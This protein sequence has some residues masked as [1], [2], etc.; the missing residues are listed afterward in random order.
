MDVATLA[1]AAAII[2]TQGIIRTRMAGDTELPYVGVHGNNEPMLRYLGEITGTK[3]TIVRRAY[4]KA[5]CAQHC[6]EK[7]Q[8]VQSVS[9]RW[10]VSGVK[11]TVL[12]HNLRP[13]LRLQHDDA[14]AALNVGVTAP[15][16]PAT[17]QKMREL[18]WDAP[19]FGKEAAA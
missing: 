19:T 17:I 3:V 10:S 15:F 14:I 8:H 6:A 12:L 4:S 5:G 16:K 9:G 2:D 13:Y 7:H 18:G 11:A 1:Y